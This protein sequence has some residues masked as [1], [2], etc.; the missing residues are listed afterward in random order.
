MTQCNGSERPAV[1][2]VRV[3]RWTWRYEFVLDGQTTW[4]TGFSTREKA[5][6]VGT[7]V[8]DEKTTALP[9]GRDA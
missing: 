5:R 9:G 3:A 6:A 8:R 4:G 1:K 7:R 2:V